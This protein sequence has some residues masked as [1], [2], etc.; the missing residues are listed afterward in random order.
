MES[1]S[2]ALIS[3]FNSGAA[4]LGQLLGTK[5]FSMSSLR[6]SLERPDVT[7]CS[8][9]S[10]ISFWILSPIFFDLDG[11]SPNKSR[12]SPSSAGSSGPVGTDVDGPGTGSCS[13]TSCVGRPSCS[14]NS[15][16]SGN[17]ASWPS[18][19]NSA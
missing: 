15:M 16:S 18:G 5:C 2:A 3:G 1:D 13:S 8:H 9:R 11:V 6:A 10:A 12:I 4:N 7:I 19:N 14:S 17:S